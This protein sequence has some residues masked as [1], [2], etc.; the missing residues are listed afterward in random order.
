MKKGI[1]LGML[2]VVSIVISGCDQADTSP[3]TSSVLLGG[4]KDV[5]GCIGSAG[6]SWC[7][8]KQKCLRIWEEECSSASSIIS[9]VSICDISNNPIQYI[10]K[11]VQTNG[12][13]KVST[14]YWKGNFLLQDN[15]CQITVS[16]WL[17]IEV[18]SPPGTTYIEPRTMER[19]LDKKLSLTGILAKQL[20]YYVIT[21]IKNVTI[22]S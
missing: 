19:Y 9:E 4:D 17:P 6:Y 15:G 22:I 11:T 16:P 2:L 18:E 1:L 8:A 14:S 5:H 20:D 7:E 21:Q 13:L 3:E 12:I 10:N